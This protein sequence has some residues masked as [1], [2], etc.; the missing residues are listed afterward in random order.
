[1]HLL[2]FFRGKLQVIIAVAIAL[3]ILFFFISNNSRPS[4][5]V[6]SHACAFA[7]FTQT[8][9]QGESVVYDLTLSPTLSGNAFELVLGDMPINAA[10]TLSQTQGTAPATVKLSFSTGSD[11]QV[12]SFGIVTKYTEIDKAG[13]RTDVWCQLN[14]EILVKDSGIA[15][16]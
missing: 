1:M 12:G 8:I 6:A 16:P 15:A 2:S 10:G 7:P 5:S 3:L 13:T 14:I 4:A 9:K 11:A